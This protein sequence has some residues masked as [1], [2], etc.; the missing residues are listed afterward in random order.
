MKHVFGNVTFILYFYKTQLSKNNITNTKK[1]KL[2]LNNP[3][4]INILILEIT[5]SSSIHNNNKND[6]K[7]ELNY[8]RR[9]YTIH[10][11]YEIYYV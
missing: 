7:I 8:M 3:I 5:L 10:Q 11:N 1:E 2:I 6:S 4:Q 9:C